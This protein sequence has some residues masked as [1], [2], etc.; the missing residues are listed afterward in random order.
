MQLALCAAALSAC[1]VKEDRSSCPC[2]LDV[3][4]SRADSA[5]RFKT[6]VISLTEARLISQE[7]VPYDDYRV[8]NYE[9]QVPRTMIR[10]S[11]IAGI[12]NAL[13][14]GDTLAVREGAQFDPV[15]AHAN[16]VDCTGKEEA[17]DVARYRKRH[18]R[19]TFILE[20]K[21]AGEEY[22]Y[23]IRIRA[24]YGGFNIFSLSP[25]CVPF[26]HIVLPDNTG[27]YHAYLPPQGDDAM[28]VDMISK[29]DGTLA[30]QFRLGEELRD[31]GYDWSKP[32]LDDISV[33]LNI[34]EARFSVEILDWDINRNMENVEF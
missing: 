8:R 3:D 21:E 7:D 11:V 1:T 31:R 12:S 33:V 17:L 24:N 23:D 20:G 5:Y 18:C 27:D 2:F 13:C 9:S 28:V 19:A 14:H 22:P 10:T 25:V 26:R 29:M 4:I 6:A 16:L 15:L 34:V 30:W 32:D